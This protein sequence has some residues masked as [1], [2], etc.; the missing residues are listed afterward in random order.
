MKVQFTKNPTKNP[1]AVTANSKM[2]EILYFL[3]VMAQGGFR[4]RIEKIVPYRTH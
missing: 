4:K 2:A 3:K 1:Y